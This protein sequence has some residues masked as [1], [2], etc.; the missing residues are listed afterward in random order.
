MIMKD[1]LLIILVLLV[2][3][4]LFA[5]GAKYGTGSLYVILPLV[6]AFGIGYWIFAR[7][8]EGE[9]NISIAASITAALAIAAFTIVFVGSCV[10]GCT[11]GGGD[12]KQQRIEMGVSPY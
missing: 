8:P 1:S 12:T 4:I 11:K 5:V 3:G 2:G 9:R 10:G 6:I 7:D